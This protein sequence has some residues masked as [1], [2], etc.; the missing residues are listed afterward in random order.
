MLLIHTSVTDYLECKLIIRSVICVWIYSPL[1]S[2]CEPGLMNWL[3][4]VSQ[5]TPHQ[6]IAP[7]ALHVKTWFPMMLH[8]I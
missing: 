5:C 3:Q 1:V 2:N 7:P 6:I 4:K 8:N